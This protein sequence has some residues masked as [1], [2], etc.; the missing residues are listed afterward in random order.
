[1]DYD[2]IVIGSGAGG[3]MAAWSLAKSGRKVLLLERGKDE[4]SPEQGQDESFMLSQMNGYDPE[5]Y[6]VN[7]RHMR[8]FTAGLPGGGTSLYGA[9]L[10]RPAA[11]D[12]EP[13]KFYQNYLPP[14][15]WQWPIDY[16]T[17]LPFYSQAEQ[18]MQVSIRSKEEFSLVDPPLEARLQTLPLSPINQRL[19]KAIL[20]YGFKP[21]HLPMAIDFT[22]CLN[23][24]TCPGYLCPNQSRSSTRNRLLIPPQIPANLAIRFAAKVKRLHS[25]GSKISGVE[26]DDANQTILKAE[27]IVL[28]A[29][30]IQSPGIILR[31]NLRDDSN[32]TGKNFMYHAGALV[33]GL[34]REDTGSADIFTKQLGFNDLYL[35]CPEFP[36]KMGYAQEIPIPG[37]I[38]IQ[39]HLPVLLPGSFARL[40]YR[41]SLTLAGVI[42]DLPLETNQVQSGPDG[43]ISIAHQFHPYDIFRA[44]YFKKQLAGILKKAGAKITAGS[45]SEKEVRHT[46]HQVGTLR[47][48]H[49]PA[50]SV[51]NANCRMHNYDN[52]YIADGSF[53]PTSLGAPPALTIMANALRVADIIQKEH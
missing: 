53:M 2:V 40:I 10:M 4:I 45:T 23:C 47:F 46:A 21:F 17:L 43:T 22:T 11:V 12:F 50:H 35:G 9:V 20:D 41:K 44:L 19:E 49:D 32:Q 3:A 37:P 18:L 6:Q 51:L 5:L 30:A 1:M 15:L 39:E 27:V 28:A 7:Q 14:A 29:G 25:S 26:L 36:H 13:G 33:T 31:S 34:Y 24:P 42:E 8:V 38:T 16:Q 52:L 48:G